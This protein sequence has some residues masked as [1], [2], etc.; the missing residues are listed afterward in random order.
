MGEGG[1]MG[2]SCQRDAR[3]S[4]LQR[5]V[6][7]ACVGGG[8]SWPKLSMMSGLAL[9][10]PDGVNPGLEQSQVTHWRLERT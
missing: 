6:S 10:N 7:P 2:C 3:S 1:A 5:T 8:C 9:V 4:S